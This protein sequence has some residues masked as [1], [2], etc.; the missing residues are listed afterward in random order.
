MEDPIRFDIYAKALPHA[1]AAAVTIMVAEG[2]YPSEIA[3]RKAAN[4]SRSEGKHTLIARSIA[5]A[6]CKEAMDNAEIAFSEFMVMQEG[7]APGEAANFCKEH[8]IHYSGSLGCHICSGF[9][10]K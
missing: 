6:S 9:Y 7:Y 3:A 5:W 10:A 2:A 4:H 8:R 1:V